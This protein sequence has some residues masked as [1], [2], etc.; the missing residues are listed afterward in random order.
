MIS[1][2]ARVE[3]RRVWAGD[4]S[5]GECDCE[6]SVGVGAG[7]VLQGTMP[8]AGAG[9]GGGAARWQ[10]ALLVGAPLALGLGYLWMRHRRERATSTEDIGIGIGN[11]SGRS[12]TRSAAVSLDEAAPPDAA[13]ALEQALRLKVQ[14]NKAFHAA[15]YEEAVSLY[16]R[17]IAACPAEKPKELATFYQNRSACYEKRERWDLVKRDCTE[18]LRLDGRYVRAFLRRARAAEKSGDLAMALEDVTAACILEHFQVR[19]TLVTADRVLKALGKMRAKEHTSSHKPSP[20]NVRYAKAYLSSF[21]KDPVTGELSPEI[22][23]APGDGFSAAR[24]ALAAAQYEQ[25]T[26]ACD[27]EVS[28]DGPQSL[29]AR[30]LRGTIRLLSGER[31]AASEDLTAVVDSP[32][33]SQTLRT[34]ALIKRATVHLQAEEVEAC[35][36]DFQQAISL[37]PENCDVYHHHGQALILLTRFD[38]ACKEFS[39]ALKLQ[40]DFAVAHVQKWYAHYNHVKEEQKITEEWENI[41]T[42]LDIVL[43]K[44]PKYQEGFVMYAEILSDR[45]LYDKARQLFEK[46]IEIDPQNANVYVHNAILHLKISSDVDKAVELIANA[47]KIDDQCLFAYETLGTIEVQ[48]DNLRKAISLFEKAIPLTRTENEMTHVFSLRDAAAAQLKVA[49]LWGL[50]APTINSD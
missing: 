26:E 3:Q 23:G 12:D 44:F 6:A 15:D 47:I 50:N 28:A 25:V 42:S 21:A 13:A 29:E 34:N 5:R 45:E 2:R 35:E 19:T 39:K 1:D 7:A 4:K 9:G 14:G 11:L 10:L 43:K 17:A 36:R 20:P 8:V 27:R 24:I 32:N 41:A 31:E 37:S 40:P 46:A 30:L 33:A 48:R 38:D 22:E 16:E 18:A 49:E